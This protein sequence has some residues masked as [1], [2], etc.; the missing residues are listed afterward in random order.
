MWVGQGN[1]YKHVHDNYKHVFVVHLLAVR[2]GEFL[3]PVSACVSATIV[4]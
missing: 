1:N 2:S 4:L 3:L